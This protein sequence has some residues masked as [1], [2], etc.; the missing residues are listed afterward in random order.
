MAEQSDGRLI[1]DDEGR[2]W[3]TALVVTIAAVVVRLVFATVLPLFPDETYYWDWSRHPA[4]GYFDHPPAIAILIHW[5]TALASLVGAEPSPLAIRFFPVLA[6]GVA[7]LFAVK[8]AQ[9]LGGGRAA[10][11]AAIVFSVM[12]L[13]ATG[14]V[15]ERRRIV[16]RGL[17]RSGTARFP[18]I[19]AILV[20]RRI[21]TRHR[22]H[23][24]VHEHPAS[25]YRHRSG[26]PPS[27]AAD[28]PARTGT[29]PRVHHRDDCL[30]SRPLLERE[31]RLGFLPLPDRARAWHT[32]GIAAEA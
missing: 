1:A 18:A 15:R 13:A 23:V 8:I 9:R 20:R 4:S 22:L 19:V 29:V 6:G 30:P 5:G 2:L 14:L 25:D 27:V 3:R 16:L 28:A 24:E 31:A 21:G 17:C 32:E 7:T 12:P 26:A 10:R 11:T